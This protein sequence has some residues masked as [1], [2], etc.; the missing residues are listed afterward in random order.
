MPMFDG[1][2][3][4]LSIHFTGAF[5]QLIYYRFIYI[6]TPDILTAVQSGGAGQSEKRYIVAL[7]AG[8]LV[9]RVFNDLR[10]LEVLGRGGAH[11]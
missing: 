10:H 9:L 5:C 8:R 11:V 7:F 3:I 1:V 2:N 4:Y 6:P